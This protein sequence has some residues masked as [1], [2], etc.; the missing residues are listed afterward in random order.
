[1]DRFLMDNLNN[2]W[3]LTPRKC[4]KKVVLDL[5]RPIAPPEVFSTGKKLAYNL[6]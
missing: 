4:V 3:P 1:M 5:R 6:V 2:K